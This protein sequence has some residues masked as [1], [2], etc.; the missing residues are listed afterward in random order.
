MDSEL[1]LGL[2]ELA[3]PSIH[4]LGRYKIPTPMMLTITNSDINQN[5]AIDSCRLLPRNTSGN[6]AITGNANTIAVA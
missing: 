6:A 2:I 3:R 1:E 4:A 5:A